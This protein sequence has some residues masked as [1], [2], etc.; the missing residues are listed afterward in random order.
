MNHLGND[1]VDCEGEGE[2]GVKHAPLRRCQ[3]H[4]H[5]GKARGFDRRCHP[6]ELVGMAEKVWLLVELTVNMHRQAARWQLCEAE[7]D[8]AD[9][10]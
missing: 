1:F 3:P 4:A 7:E 2:R 6:I 5:R 10:C 8:H 9:L